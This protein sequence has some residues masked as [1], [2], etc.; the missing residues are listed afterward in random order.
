MGWLLV[1]AGL[2]ATS[3]GWV[4]ARKFGEAWRDLTLES[5]SGALDES[6][7]CDLVSDFVGLNE[8]RRKV[9]CQGELV[10]TGEAARL[11]GVKVDWEDRTY[12]LARV[13]GWKVL[14]AVKGVPCFPT[15]PPEPSRAIESE[16]ERVTVFTRALMTQRL[17]GIRMAMT[18]EVRPRKC[19]QGTRARRSD[20]PLLEFELLQGGGSESWAFLSTGWLRDA[21]IKG[22]FDSLLTASERWATG[23]PWVAVV[24]SASRKEPVGGLLDAR[25]IHGELTG[26]MT[27][28]DA[29]AGE[30]L[31]EA[32]FSFQSSGTLKPLPRQRW[33]RLDFGPLRE[34]ATKERVDADLEERFRAA[35]LK[36]INEM[37]GYHAWPSLH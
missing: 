31:C 32:P 36:T 6:L 14:R 7:A 26:T 11:A 22:D 20:I 34:I 19:A 27:V 24:T 15:P 18:S 30:L 23:R 25:F 3:F 16:Q 8:Y 13:P 4:S 10:V 12:C 1:I 5:G 21:V 37:T 9:K 29:E 33:A 28:I 17:E 2:Y 35:A